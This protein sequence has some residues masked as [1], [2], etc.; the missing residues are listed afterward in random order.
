MTPSDL[1]LS[2]R[3]AV[4]MGWEEA[5]TYAEFEDTTIYPEMGLKWCLVVVEGE[6]I[7]SGGD[8]HPEE[9]RPLSIP[10]HAALVTEEAARRGWRVASSINP[11]GPHSNAHT[12]AQVETA[13]SRKSGKG[14]F[15]VED[16]VTPGAW[17][18][19]VCRA[20]LY[21]MEAIER[22]AAEGSV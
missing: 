5:K 22:G 18:R 1:D 21:T 2:I 8:Q 19:A 3:L 11:C 20:V 9:W 4:F 15:A 7:I 12:T 14:W 17:C 10:D 13:D 16:D 6:I